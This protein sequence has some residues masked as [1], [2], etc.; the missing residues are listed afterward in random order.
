MP[1]VLLLFLLA[2]SFLS[3]L[4]L[5]SSTF[6]CSLPIWRCRCHSM[7]VYMC[8]YFTIFDCRYVSSFSIWKRKLQRKK[9]ARTDSRY[10][11]KTRNK[12][13]NTQT[14]RNYYSLRTTCIHLTAAASPVYINLFMTRERVRNIV[15]RS[16]CILNVDE[17]NESKNAKMSIV[18]MQ[19][20]V[21]IKIFHSFVHPYRETK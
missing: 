17:R 20:C 7:R 12:I 15:Y 16:E 13:R 14:N 6:S 19:V 5:T 10:P 18:G 2:S 11:Y 21:R 4:C 1:F 8:M 3:L 9:K